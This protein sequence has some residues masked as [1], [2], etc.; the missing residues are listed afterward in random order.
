MNDEFKNNINATAEFY[1]EQRKKLKTGIISEIDKDDKK[2]EY[3]EINLV[4]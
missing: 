4:K 3:K 2:I 1:E